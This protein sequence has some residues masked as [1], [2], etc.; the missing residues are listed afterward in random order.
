MT[1]TLVNQPI[2]QCTQRPQQRYNRW[3]VLAIAKEDLQQE[4]AGIADILHLDVNAGHRLHGCVFNDWNGAELGKRDI[5][6]KKETRIF[7]YRSKR[8]PDYYYVLIWSDQL[9]R[10]GCSCIDSIN[11][12]TCEHVHP[13]SL[14]SVQPATEIAA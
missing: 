5:L 9:R 8:H 4:L 14:Y 1:P 12:H 11:G 3:H 7:F 13:V 2:I 6:I 10:Y